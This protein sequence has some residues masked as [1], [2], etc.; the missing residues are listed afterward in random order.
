MPE[1]GDLSTRG[2]LSRPALSSDSEPLYALHKATMLTYVEAI[3]GP[4]IDEVQLAMHH[5]WL[6]RGDPQVVL[7]DD[8]LVAVVDWTW[9]EHDLYVG[10]IEVRPDLQGAGIGTMLLRRLAVVAAERSKPVVLE[11]IDVNPAR[12]LYERLG[13]AAFT[14]TGRKV[15]L[16]LDH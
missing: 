12:R 11:V 4:W 9:R 15:H 14:T 10:R 6:E 3:Y 16:R 1:L 7:R 8:E 13:F 5:E 2:Y